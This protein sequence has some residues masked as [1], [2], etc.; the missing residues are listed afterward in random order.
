MSKFTDPSQIKTAVVGYGGTFNMGRKHLEQMKLAGMTPY[1]VAEINPSR[2]EAAK[3]DFPGIQTYSS[4]AKMLK[5]S[6]VDLVTI[7]TPHNTHARLALH[8]LRA[9]R[10]VICEKPLAITTAE[11]D[12]IIAA[13]EKAGVVLSTYH[14]RH[15]DGCILEA[16]KHIRAGEIGEVF[17]IEAHRAAYGKP[18][19][20]WRSSKSISG[21]VLYDWGV[22]MLEYCLQIIDS[23]IVEVSG[24]AKGGFWGPQ[25]PWNDDC[26]EDEAFL[27]VR[28]ANGTWLTLC[29]S[30][31]D[32]NPKRGMLEITGTRGS[33]ILNTKDY[34]I[35]NVV[36]GKPN[37]IKGENPKS[38][39]QRFYQNIADH[40][41]GGHELIITPQWA[42]RPIHILD[43]GCRSAVKGK[44]IKARYE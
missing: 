22:H 31:L 17:R 19:D 37:V 9:G 35:I 3:V 39:G 41:T 40:L 15:W 5:K 2:M 29:I 26:N 20:W 30:S 8:A 23:R 16:L 1:A 33:Y 34:E 4:L 36:S 24:F 38:E 27:T 21:G 28:F 10:H 13:A 6:D 43:L 12:A 14:N 18:K 7:I 11:C 32:S 42:R 25:T 44:A